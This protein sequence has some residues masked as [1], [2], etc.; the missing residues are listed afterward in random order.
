MEEFGAWVGFFGLFVAAI[1]ALI[2]SLLVSKNRNSFELGVEVRN[3]LNKLYNDL[4][5]QHSNI[6]EYNDNNRQ[7]NYDELTQ[8]LKVYFDFILNKYNDFRLYYSRLYTY[9]LES[10]IYKY[11]YEKSISQEDNIMNKNEYDSS[12]Q[13]IKDAYELLINEVRTSLI[14]INNVS[15]RTRNYLDERQ[16][17]YTSC[18]NRLIKGI[19]E[20]IPYDVIN[21]K[22][23]PEMNC[24]EKAS[25]VVSYR[26]KRFEKEYKNRVSNTNL[27]EKLP[28]EK[29]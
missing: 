1:I 14:G 13:S 19:N 2:S 22:E 16:N 21:F 5:N 23:K 18:A 15:K 26:I 17:E 4:I 6:L 20:N 11:Y 24:L 28:I 25:H 9:E 8:G 29:K 10:A 7:K 3:S 27:K 12:Y